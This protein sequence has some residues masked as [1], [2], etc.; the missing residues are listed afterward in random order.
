M[1]R[2]MIEIVNRKLQEI[3]DPLY[4]KVEGWKTVPIP[5]DEDY[6]VSTSLDN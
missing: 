4:Q 1:H 5:I 2:H 6:P 3:H